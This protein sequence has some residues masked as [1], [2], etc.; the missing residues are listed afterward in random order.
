MLVAQDIER[1][2]LEDEV[3]ARLCRE[4]EPPGDQHSQN[5]A[6][7]EQHGVIVK[8]THSGDHAVAACSHLIRRLA[9]G[10]AGVE[11]GPSRFRLADLLRGDPFVLT[12]VPLGQIVGDFRAVKESRKFAGAPCSLPRTAQDE[13]KVP[14][15]EFTLEGG[16]LT[17][18]L[19]SQGDVGERG[20]PAVF[21]PFGFTVADEDDLGA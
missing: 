21:A 13:L 3:A 6:V 11:D 12:V 16:R 10:G 14:P 15:R 8:G 9:A 19:K 4:I 1:S 20:M 2:R 17:F 7:G 18:P 5:M